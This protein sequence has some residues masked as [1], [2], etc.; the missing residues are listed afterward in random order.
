MAAIL[1]AA[2][3]FGQAALVPLCHL[4]FRCGHLEWLKL[5]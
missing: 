3:S 5:R 2:G 4:D 1:P